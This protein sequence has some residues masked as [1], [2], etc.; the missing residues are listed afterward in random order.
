MSDPQP[1]KLFIGG[2]NWDTTTEKLEERFAE[3]GTV[4]DCVIMKDKFTNQ[5]R[6]FGFVTLEDP[7]VAERLAAE[8]HLEIDGR[9]VEVKRATPKEPQAAPERGR[10][11]YHANAWGNSRQNFPRGGGGGG[12]GGG[13]DQNSSYRTPKIF[14]GGLAWSTTDE[15]FRQHF[16]EF[17]EVANC[18]IMVNR[19]GKPRGFGYLTFVSESS[20]DLA[21]VQHRHIISNREVEVKKAIPKEIMDAKSSR[22]DRDP[23]GL[24]PA[25]DA[26]GYPAD[27]PG[28]FGGDPMDMQRELMAMGMQRP[29]AMGM[30]LPL[31]AMGNLTQ[32]MDRMTMAPWPNALGIG[33]IPGVP[34]GAGTTG[35]WGGAPEWGA[36]GM[37]MMGMPLQWGDGAP[38]TMSSG[39]PAMPPGS[40][41]AMPHGPAAMGAAGSGPPVATSGGGVESLASAHNLSA[42]DLERLGVVDVAK[43]REMLAMSSSLPPEQQMGL[44]N[45]QQQLAAMTG[46]LGMS[47]GASHWESPP[48][49]VYE[50][51]DSLDGFAAS[52]TMNGSALPEQPR[53][54]TAASDPAEGYAAYQ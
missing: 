40:M 1:G 32:R 31:D 22:I 6:G 45:Y 36:Q 24:P 42:S 30:G 47:A 41:P 39:M 17:G 2:L 3:Y 10:T 37:N 53:A 44:A 46:A 43:L 26:A 16:E 27:I 19:E 5:P 49:A 52:G 51:P 11:G 35:V 21:V 18:Q 48:A 14:V 4:V 38:M 28:H 20:A 34:F 9:Q 23:R 50:S 33:G 25:M 13:G 15:E 8:R 29:G 7:A 12:G 54:D